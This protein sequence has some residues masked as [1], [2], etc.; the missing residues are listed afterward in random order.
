MRGYHP[1]HCAPRRPGDRMRHYFRARLRRR[2]F[3]WLTLAILATLIAVVSVLRA[4]GSSHDWRAHQHGVARFVSAILLPV[5]D[6]PVERQR[7][8]HSMGQDLGIAAQVRL[9]TGELLGE[10]DFPGRCRLPLRTPLVRDGRLLGQVE[11][12][13]DGGMA[14]SPW[15]R[16][17]LALL[18]AVAVL[19][20][21]AGWVSHRV[22]Q[23]LS[24]LADVA[25]QLGEGK[26]DRRARLRHD[27]VG[28][29][30]ELSLAINEMASR[31]EKQLKDQR[32][33]LAA[34][35]HELRT[36]L[37]RIRLLLEMARDGE[38]KHLDEIDQ[39]VVEM[40]RLVG[41]LLAQARLD[42]S[43]LSRRTVS[44]QD[45][46]A[47]SLERAG[48]SDGELIAE[49]V[50]L[51]A[52]AT[53]LSRALLALLDNAKKHG[54]PPVVLRV[55]KVPDGVRFSVEDHGAGFSDGEEQRAFEAFRRGA[56]DRGGLG[57]GLSLVR[58]IAEAHGGRVFATNAA[59]GGAV[60]GFTLP[61]G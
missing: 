15:K 12:C 17:I 41:E 40:D 36:P 2:L 7:L 47:R 9:P 57:L 45:L 50:T 8:L 4:T 23:P 53:L 35:S 5:W 43:A 56:K 48:L 10:Q 26:L 49:E 20:G 42:F 25:R 44:A 11:L 6:V 32:E 33:L 54:A 59:S 3:V 21:L 27:E 51:S 38:T 18:A 46:A 39:E 58:R 14:R 52:D 24:E 22:G 16:T 34:V 1:P 61:L 30:G 55:A 31:I 37:T 19:W 13:F 29:V 60:V 28:E